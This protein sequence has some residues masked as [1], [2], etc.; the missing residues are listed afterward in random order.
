MILCVIHCA[1]SLG[2]LIFEWGTPLSVYYVLL[3]IDAF[4]FAALGY[5][6]VRFIRVSGHPT[7]LRCSA[8][9]Q[10]ASVE[11]GSPTE[12]FAVDTAPPKY[13]GTDPEAWRPGVHAGAGSEY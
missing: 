6:W 5:C 11:Q 1:L 4:V 12:M 3:V 7:F 10:E 8:A 2:D 13:S 9:R